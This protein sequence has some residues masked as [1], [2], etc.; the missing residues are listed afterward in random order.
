[1][2]AALFFFF[3]LF[4]SLEAAS[5]P[6][7]CVDPLLNI[8]INTDC[9]DLRLFKFP[10]FT[11]LIS[12]Q[13]ITVDP[14]NSIQIPFINPSEG[15]LLSL[16]SKTQLLGF[17]LLAKAVYDTCPSFPGDSKKFLNF[18]ENDDPFNTNQVYLKLLNAEGLSGNKG[19]YMD[20]FQKAPEVYDFISEIG[21][22]INV[23]MSDINKVLPRF[24]DEAEYTI[25][26]M[27][28]YSQFA[29]FLPRDKIA[30]EMELAREHPLTHQ[31]DI[32]LYLNYDVFNF[33]IPYNQREEIFHEL[34]EVCLKNDKD[35]QTF[36]FLIDRLAIAEAPIKFWN[37][38]I[39]VT[40]IGEG[41]GCDLKSDKWTDVK[42]GL[43]DGLRPCLVT[44]VGKTNVNVS[45]NKMLQICENYLLK[46]KLF[47]TL[48]NCQHFA[49]QA[50][51]MVTGIDLDFENWSIM[52][53]HSLYS[54]I[55]PM[56]DFIDPV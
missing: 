56:L 25:Q 19:V 53:A 9:S 32:I 6:A 18:H 21:K 2:R 46:Y 42:D 45:M 7:V 35:D 40:Y 36:H 31:P 12:F 51:D 8:V 23:K 29:G 5:F 39:R 15:I 41:D 27:K 33:P 30:T 11:C 3:L 24:N 17:P 49:T 48:M 34:T 37:S 54:K 55:E 22:P 13:R 47:N 20:F 52:G 1:M 44:R 16:L 28:L 43:C 50:F 38:L 10:P 26:S 14:I 4:V